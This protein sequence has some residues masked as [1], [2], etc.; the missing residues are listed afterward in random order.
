[1][2]GYLHWLGL[3]CEDSSEGSYA[4][5]SE[6]KGGKMMPIWHNEEEKAGAAPGRLTN[7]SSPSENMVLNMKRLIIKL[8]RKSKP[9]RHG[10]CCHDLSLHWGKKRKCTDIQVEFPGEKWDWVKTSF[11]AFVLLIKTE[12]VKLLL[13]RNERVLINLFKIE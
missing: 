12:V 6:E 4:F 2:I 11:S 5:L 13:W 3:I 9:D 1:M 10:L 7:M 8:T